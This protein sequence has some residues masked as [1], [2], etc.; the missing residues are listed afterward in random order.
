MRSQ[1]R[2]FVVLAILALLL[3]SFA[4][5]A[6]DSV[7]VTAQ[8]AS[9]RLKPDTHSIVIV[10]VGAGT[11][12]DVI[13]RQGN[14]FEVS[15]PLSENGLRRTG[16]I[17]GTV[18]ELIH[19]TAPSQKDAI[20]ERL[21]G[22]WDGHTIYYDRQFK[23]YKEGAEQHCEFIRDAKGVKFIGND[24]QVLA[25]DDVYIRYAGGKLYGSYEAG[26]HG[27]THGQVWTEKFT[28]D[29]KDDKTLVYQESNNGPIYRDPRMKDEFHKRQQ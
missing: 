21:V 15:L 25:E 17:S 5:A 13:A 18:V 12:F 16:F 19:T 9:V 1:V 8:N 22:K 4:S 14:W 6:S 2:C 23:Q 24:G 28:L 11:V 3:P 26:K 7:R 29:L 20:F 10:K 27:G